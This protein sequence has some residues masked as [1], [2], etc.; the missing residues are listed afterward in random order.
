MHRV[1]GPVVVVVALSL[2]LAPSAAARPHDKLVGGLGEL[3]RGGHP[4]AK[5]T[6]PAVQPL[7][8]IVRDGKVLV[9]VYVRGAVTSRADGLRG[10][11]MRVEAVSRHE[12]QKM[13]EGW[14]PVSALADVAALDGTQAVVPVYEANFN[15]GAAISEGDAAHHG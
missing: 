3:A 10:H 6:G 5:P 13:V 11:G 4:W 7:P 9:G 12:P 1:A 2:V 14:L 8:G 15:T